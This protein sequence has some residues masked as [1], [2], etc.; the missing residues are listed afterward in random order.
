M[1]KKPVFVLIPGGGMS[2]WEW[3]D[4]IGYLKYPYIMISSRIEPNTYENRLNSMLGDLISHIA[5]KIPADEDNLVLVGHSGG[6]MLAALTAKSIA[7]RVKHIVFV[8]GNIPAHGESAVSG[9]PFLLR[10]LNIA[11]IK[12]QIKHDSIPMSKIEKTIRKTFMNGAP[13]ETVQYVMRQN[14]L[15]EPLCVLNGRVDWGGFPKVGMTY[16]A[17]T[18]D[19]TLGADKQRAMGN[20]LGIEDFR[21]IGSC[22]MVTL[23]KPKELASILN[24]VA[25]S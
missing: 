6:G 18:G 8:A 10:R 12:S 21:E 25:E 22:H 7:Q 4:L 9:L 23:V 3:K 19:N 24:S 2:D 20:N 11:A 13:E 5:A 16:V 14:L 17:L 15:P 1:K